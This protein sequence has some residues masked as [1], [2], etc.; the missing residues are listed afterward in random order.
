MV[1]KSFQNMK[2]LCEPYEKNGKM[3]VRVLNKKTQKEREVRFYTEKEYIK[4]YGPLP[5][6]KKEE[7]NSS[8][9]TVGAYRSTAK[10]HVGDPY[11]KPQKDVLGFINGYITIFKGNTYA[12]KDYLKSIGCMYKKLWGW[13]LSSDKELP[14][15]FPVDLTPVKLYWDKV[16]NEEG[17]LYTDADVKEEV[18]KLIYDPGASE[19]QGSIGER[20][21][22]YVTI[23]RALEIGDFGDILHIMKDSNENEYVWKT[24]ARRLEEAKTYHLRGTVKEHKSFRNV[25]Q[26][27]LTRCTLVKEK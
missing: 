19:W 14:E 10:D 24:S 13:C 25:K 16:G 1:A 26:T 27:V 11:W 23:V 3:Y 20:L 22:L 15:D 7:K 4:L 9:K 21:D 12:H 5:E 18:D 17:N 2:I 6:D 8:T